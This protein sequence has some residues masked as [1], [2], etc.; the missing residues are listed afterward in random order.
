[1]AAAA[2]VLFL[3]GVSAVLSL[4][5]GRPH[6]P[7]AAV[8]VT[9]VAAVAA[10]PPAGPAGREDPA[11]AVRPAEYASLARD[12]LGAIDSQW[13]ASGKGAAMC[14][15]GVHDCSEGYELAAAHGLMGEVR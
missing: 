13:F 5:G 3:V 9:S 4:R 2:C 6:L 15:A 8:A 7:T 11:A 12:A 14:A 1:M 10:P